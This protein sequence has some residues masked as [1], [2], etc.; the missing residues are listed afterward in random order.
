MPFRNA[1]QKPVN[2]GLKTIKKTIYSA[3]T[4][5]RHFV[6]NVPLGKNGYT[7]IHSGMLAL[8]LYLTNPR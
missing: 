7:D 2:E 8:Y 3:Y 1:M 4:E 6:Q 5:F